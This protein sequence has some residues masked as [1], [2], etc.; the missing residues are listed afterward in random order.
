MHLKE[1]WLA[2]PHPDHRGGR[3]W[4]VRATSSFAADAA[5]NASVRVERESGVG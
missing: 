3:E 5:S 4:E 2:M 1:N